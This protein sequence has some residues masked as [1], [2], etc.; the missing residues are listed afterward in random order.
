MS[1]N[2]VYCLCFKKRNVFNGLFLLVVSSS[3][4]TGGYDK[5]SFWGSI[6]MIGVGKGLNDSLSILLFSI[7]EINFSIFILIFLINW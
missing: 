2:L 4:C 1:R 5:I 3:T 6:S 7:L